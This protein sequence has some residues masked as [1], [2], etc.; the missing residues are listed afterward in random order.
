MSVE[1]VQDL[2]EESE[3]EHT[4]SRDNYSNASKS[5][6]RIS[7]QA[8]Q[9][10]PLVTPGEEQPFGHVESTEQPFGQVEAALSQSMYDEADNHNSNILSESEELSKDSD[11]YNDSGEAFVDSDSVSERSLSEY[12]VSDQSCII[13]T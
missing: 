11:S 1:E 2:I 6:M 10:Y 9:Y 7:S 4:F 5:H 8:K 12:L 13:H 3:D